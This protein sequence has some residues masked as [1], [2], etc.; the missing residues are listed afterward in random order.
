[1]KTATVHQAMTHLFRMLKEAQAGETIIT[2][3]GTTPVVRLSAID[4][5]EPRRPKAGTRTSPPVHYAA[6]AFRPLSEPELQEEWRREPLHHRDPFDRSTA[7]APAE[8]LSPGMAAL[9]QEPRGP[10][11]FAVD[12]AAGCHGSSIC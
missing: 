7:P 11:G 1:M 12:R 2:L 8:L 9:A 6:E 3:N 10:A 5:P 4:Q